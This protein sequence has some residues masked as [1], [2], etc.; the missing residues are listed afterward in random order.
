MTKPRT[1]TDPVPPSRSGLWYS[2]TPAE[3]GFQQPIFQ[4]QPGNAPADAN[5][6]MDEATSKF[7][8]DN[9]EKIKIKR[10][11]QK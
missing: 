3:L 1:P 4:P 8:K 11:A 5:K 7:L 6:L 2:I 9:A 10:Y